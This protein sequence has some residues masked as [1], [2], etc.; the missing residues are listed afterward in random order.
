MLILSINLTLYNKDHI[1][2]LLN[3]IKQHKIDNPVYIVD[4]HQTVSVSFD[5]DYEQYELIRDFAVHFEDYELTDD[6]E[7]GQEDI[8]LAIHRNQ[9]AFSSDNWGRRWNEDDIH[10]STYLVKIK[11]QRPASPPNPVFWALFGDEI[12]EYKVHIV[13]GHT[14]DT[15]QKGYLVVKDDPKVNE[16]TEIISSLKIT[17]T[18]A[19]WEGY[20]LMMPEI[21]KAYSEY[22]KSKKKKPKP[23]VEKNE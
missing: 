22:K 23:R 16:N 18:D 4:L 13:P 1:K 6:I 19:F 10:K 14:P 15:G 3:T 12:K 5:S 9:S 2:L 11:E 7:S 17:R 20:R 21:D 8:L